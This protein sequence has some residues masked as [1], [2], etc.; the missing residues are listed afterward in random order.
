MNLTTAIRRHD[1]DGLVYGALCM[2]AGSAATVGLGIPSAFAAWFQG[3]IMAW[4]VLDGF[5][6]TQLGGKLGSYANSEQMLIEYGC[7]AQDAPQAEAWMGHAMDERRPSLLVDRPARGR[8][9]GSWARLMGELSAGTHFAEP[10]PSVD[11]HSTQLINA[12][13]LL[14]QDYG[15]AG[16]TLRNSSLHIRRPKRFWR[17]EISAPLRGG[18]LSVKVPE[19]TRRVYLGMALPGLH[20][21]GGRLALAVFS[22]INFGGLTAMMAHEGALSPTRTYCQLMQYWDRAFIVCDLR[23][24]SGSFHDS[25]E[26]LFDILSA[27]VRFDWLVEKAAPYY[28]R[29]ILDNPRERVRQTA[30]RV[31]MGA[32]LLEDLLRVVSWRE[33]L[34]R[35]A[36][37]DIAVV[38]A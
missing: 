36:T 9:I 31:L 26:P 1:S 18:N 6:M 24:E 7:S 8:A 29:L 28:L 3:Q 20:Q 33:H 25:M 17:P 19:R 27:P 10:P 34:A 37:P 32:D 14:R 5:P 12:L 16:V 38:A 13:K 2:P 23:W 15:V 22:C 35:A 4:N 21:D 11:E 30:F